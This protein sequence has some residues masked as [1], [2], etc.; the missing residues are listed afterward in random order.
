MRLTV[1]GRVPPVAVGEH[2][3]VVGTVRPDRTIVATDAI[4][5]PATNFR[6]MYVLSFGAG[7]WV[8]VRLLRGWTVDRTALAVRRRREPIDL[9]TR[10]RSAIRSEEDPADA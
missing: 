4:A 3:Q 7:C 5:V 1:T 9:R 6:S 10:L 2:L 8:L